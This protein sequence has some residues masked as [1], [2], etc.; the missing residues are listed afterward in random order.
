MSQSC[1]KTNKN[2]VT[3]KEEYSDNFE[4]EFYEGSEYSNYTAF[5]Y[6]DKYIKMRDYMFNN[7]F[8]FI[9]NNLTDEERN[10]FTENFY[11]ECYYP[12]LQIKARRIYAKDFCKHYLFSPALDAENLQFFEKC[13]RNKS[14]NHENTLN[15]T[16]K[17]LKK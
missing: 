10:I 13:K 12:Y 1:I 17:N 14:K 8:K 11:Y 9:Y 15:L 4:N 16:I 2:P 7:Q 5:W 6:Y 3:I